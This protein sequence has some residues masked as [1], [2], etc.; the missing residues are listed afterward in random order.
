M[1]PPFGTLTVANCQSPSSDPV[2][3]EIDLKF[4]PGEKI[5]LCGPSGSGKS[6]LVMAVLLMMELKDG[7]VT[8]DDIDTS[9][10]AGS[11][12][13]K[14]LNVVP[15]EPFFMP[16]TVKLNIDP[17]GQSSN[18][19]IVAALGRVGLWDKIDG[20][21]GLDADLDPSELSHGERQLL[22]LAR[23]MLVPSKILILDEAMSRYE[24]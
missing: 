9:T 4:A 10:V 12:L 21:G 24:D 2:L 23:A 1:Y 13:R 6:S 3:K 7:R 19:S 22:C 15:Q 5:V 11:S 16:G 18:E 8:I 20:K 17:R 14:Q